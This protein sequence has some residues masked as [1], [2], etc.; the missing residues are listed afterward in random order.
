MEIYLEPLSEGNFDDYFRIYLEEN[1]DSELPRAMRERAVRSSIDAECFIT[2]IIRQAGTG[3]ALG[4]C[5][6]HNADEDDWE[7]GIYVRDGHRG[8]GVGSA[9]LA[10]FLDEL[11]ATRG[12]REL[13]AKILVGNEASRRLFEGLGA[14]LV[15]TDVM[16]GPENGRLEQD[17]AARDE[18]IDPEVLERLRQ[19]EALVLGARREIWVYRV[20]WPGR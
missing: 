13:W 1:G 11:A 15:R 9:A 20:A 3:E 18:P 7:L 10:L 19:I 4:Y 12:R 16:G 17:L 6:V 2:R 5:D 14:E 8:Q